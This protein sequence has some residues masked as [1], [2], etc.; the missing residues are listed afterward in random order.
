MLGS[1]GACLADNGSHILLRNLRGGIDVLRLLDW[2]P[3][4]WFDH[5]LTVDDPFDLDR[6][7][8]FDLYPLNEGK[9][10]TGSSSGYASVLHWNR[11]TAM[12]KHRH[13]DRYG[14][15][16]SQS[17]LPTRELTASFPP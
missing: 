1:G 12:T 2:S 7:Y 6:N 9:V 15:L 13:R 8:A 17:A 4:V 14:K 16:F 3:W 11:R 5:R 10:L